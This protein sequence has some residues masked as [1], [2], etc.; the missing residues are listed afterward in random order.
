MPH[1]FTRTRTLEYTPF[2]VWLH[3]YKGGKKEILSSGKNKGKK[4]KN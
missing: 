2:R 4:K 1:S 3:L